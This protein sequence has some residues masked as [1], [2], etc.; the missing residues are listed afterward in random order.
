MNRREFVKALAGIPLL[1]LLAKIPEETG[2]LKLAG[3]PDLV[4]YV[5]DCQ[6]SEDSL[7]EA[8]TTYHTEPFT[9]VNI[10][11]TGED[12]TPIWEYQDGQGWKR[13]EL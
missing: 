6:A 3:Y 9:G 5:S 2:K 11:F 4:S 12:P 1:G 8:F 7:A 13:I 10:T